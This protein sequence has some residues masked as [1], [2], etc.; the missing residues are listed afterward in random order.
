MEIYHNKFMA[1]VLFAEY[2]KTLIILNRLHK[3]NQEIL[4]VHTPIL[5]PSS[6][7]KVVSLTTFFTFLQDLKE[8]PYP[9]TMFTFR[10]MFALLA[11]FFNFR[12]MFATLAPFFNFRK[13]FTS[14]APFFTAAVVIVLTP[15]VKEHI[16]LAVSDYLFSMYEKWLSRFSTP[17]DTVIIEEFGNLYVSNQ[18]YEAARVH[19]LN[20]ISISTKPKRFKVRKEGRQNESIIDIVENEEF[21]EIVNGNSLNWKLRAVR[22]KEYQGDFTV[23]YFELSFDKGLEKEVLESYLRGIVFR[24][25]EMVKIY[26]RDSRSYDGTMA[27]ASLD[28]DRGWIY[29]IFKHPFTFEKLAMDPEKKKMLKADLDRFREG[30][31]LYEDVGKT[32]KRG[33]LLYGPPGTGKSSLIAAMANHL[34]FDIYELNLS[35]RLTDVGL[36]NILLSTTNRSILVIEDIDCGAELD[37]HRRE[38]DSVS[39]LYSHKILF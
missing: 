7:N 19:L 28:R 22:R 17:R 32:W 8:Q 26:S 37:Y 1:D 4:R 39:I 6:H 38:F 36:R 30:K 15:F 35:S 14:L 11:P 29:A 18:V 23:R 9:Q 33:Y 3:Q 13:M 21:I 25:E 27:S 12:E 16:P 34:K 31:D 10:D 20:L 5:H 24:Y 2:L